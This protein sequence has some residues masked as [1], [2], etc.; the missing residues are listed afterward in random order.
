MLEDEEAVLRQHHLSEEAM[1]ELTATQPAPPM[2][3]PAGTLRAQSDAMIAAAVA[4]A[5]GNIAAAARALGI[6]RNTLY[7]R[8]TAARGPLN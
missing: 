8:M 2:E 6:S 1:L 3:R 4:D 7:R 5:G